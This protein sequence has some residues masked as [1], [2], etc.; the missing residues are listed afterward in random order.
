VAEDGRGHRP[1]EREWNRR[2][3]RFERGDRR[4]SGDAVLLQPGPDLEAAQR[5]VD[6]PSKDPVERPRG[7]AV[8]GEPELERRH[9][10]AGPADPEGAGAE[11]VAGEAAEGTAGLRADHP[12]DPDAGAS[13]EPPDRLRG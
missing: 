7:E 11:T 8:L 3:R 1:A 6:V 13:L 4:G 12:V 5:A 10:P 9:V 2:R